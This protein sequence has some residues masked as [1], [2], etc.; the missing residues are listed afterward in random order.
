MPDALDCGIAEV[1]FWEMTLGEIDRA[2]ESYNRCFK[3]EQQDKAA[4]DY[5]LAQLIIAGISRILDSS[6]KFPEIY[7]AYPQLFNN[8]QT[9][10]IKQKQRTQESVA[11]F[12]QFAAMHNLKKNQGGG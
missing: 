1:D 8:E 3:R 11:R 5:I 2:I 10:E 12:M 7:E 6:A 9:E 4:G